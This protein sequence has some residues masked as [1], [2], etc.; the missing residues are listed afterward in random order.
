MLHQLAA[1]AQRPRGLVDPRRPRTA[2]A[3]R[4]PPRRTRPARRHCRTP[5]ST[6]STARR[7]PPNATAATPR[8]A[9]SRKPRWPRSASRPR[10]ALPLRAGLVHDRH[11]A[12]PSP[13]SASSRPA[14][15]PSC[16]ARC[17]RSTPGVTG[18]T[19]R[20]PHQPPGPAGTGPLVTF[21]RS[22][23]SHARSPPA[24][25]PAR[26]RRRLRRPDPLE[27]PDRRLPHLHHA[28]AVRRGHLLPGPAGTAARRPG[29][30]L[31]RPARH[32][33][34]PRHVT[35]SRSLSDLP[36]ALHGGRPVVPRR[37]PPRC[38]TA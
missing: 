15:T 29:A 18:Q 22:G 10:D 34:R 28:P 13:R 12:T 19:A 35:A 11:A 37:D 23:L 3:R 31:L 2:R 14:S 6:S 24:A 26:P 1:R 5:T 36:P 8:P 21:A 27:L 16:S 9:A 4:S 30:H 25:Q 33:R 32:R 20:P 38:T 7:H 17:R